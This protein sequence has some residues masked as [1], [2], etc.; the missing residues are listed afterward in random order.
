MATDQEFVNFVCDQL[1]DSGPV[2]YRKMFGEYAIYCQEKVVALACD[3]QLFVKPTDA[4]RRA[5]GSPEFGA[6][7]PGAKPHFLITDA[8]ENREVLTQLIRETVRALPLPK[9]QKKKS[10]SKSKS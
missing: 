9:P 3:N 5:I 7:Y 8:L 10:K 2:T 1:R 6:P 4:G